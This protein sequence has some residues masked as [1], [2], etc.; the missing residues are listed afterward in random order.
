MA[1]KKKKWK[2]S[3]CSARKEWVNK[4][5]NREKMSLNLKFFKTGIREELL[6][7]KSL[8]CVKWKMLDAKSHYS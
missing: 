5:L 4:L 1:V 8:L 7:T 3:E 2:S 6:L